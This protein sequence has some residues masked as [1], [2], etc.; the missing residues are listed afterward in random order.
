[1]NRLAFLRVNLFFVSYM[2]LLFC[3]NLSFF[4]LFFFYIFAGLFPFDQQF[5][6]FWWIWS[7]SNS[8]LKVSNLDSTSRSQICNYLHFS[9]NTLTH[10]WL[11]LVRSVSTCAH[12]LGSVPSAGFISTCFTSFQTAEM[13]VPYYIPA[14]SVWA[15]NDF[16]SSTNICVLLLFLI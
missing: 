12:S 15:P 6:T 14:S 2:I 8:S 9:V 5:N 4:I 7:V 16:M 3:K 10:I 11:L 13:V 1:M